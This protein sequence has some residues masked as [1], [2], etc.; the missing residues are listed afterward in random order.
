MRVERTADGE[1]ILMSPTG[2]ETGRR[3]FALSVAFGIWAEKDG[4]GV[5]FDSSTAFLLPNGAERSPD[6]AWVKKER[7][8]ALTPRQRE[9]FPPLCPDFVVELKSPTD[10]L[11]SLHAKLR[12]HLENGASLGWLVDPESRRVCVYERGREPVCLDAPETLSGEP[13][14]PGLSVPLAKVW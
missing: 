14:L 5:A 6:L 3:N 11:E 12:E 1:I 9:R 13:L 2:G 10:A 7:W 8:D 4:S